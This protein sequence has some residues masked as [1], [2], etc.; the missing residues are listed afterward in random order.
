[1]CF[2]TVSL[3]TFCA[4]ALGAGIAPAQDSKPET[5]PAS[6][7]DLP[8]SASRLDEAVRL[9]AAERYDEAVKVL[10]ALCQRFPADVRAAGLLGSAQLELH[11]YEDAKA[12]Y[13]GLVKRAPKESAAWVGY[14]EALQRLGALDEAA[15]AV[16]RALDLEPNRVE[17]LFS[18]GQ[19]AWRR[20][21]AVKAK[22]WLGKGL[23][24][25]PWGTLAPAA[26]YTLSQ[27]AVLEGRPQD[28]EREKAAYEKK[29]H[30]AE[31]RA[32]MERRL[33]V[34]PDDAAARRVLAGL[35]RE[36]G[37]GL[38][39][40]QVLEPLRREQPKDPRICLEVAE[41]LEVAGRRSDAAATAAEAARLA[42]RS[43]TPLRVLAE[44]RLRAGELDEAWT[45]LRRAL[46]LDPSATAEPAL[47]AAAADLEGAASRAGRAQLAAEVREARRRLGD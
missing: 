7:P 31:K 5:S 32:A 1:V 39:A 12:T 16:G 34:K 19:L 8:E 17:A 9:Y 44:M 10:E 41:S 37:D 40:L 30:W 18:A 3:W 22:E 21:D 29:Y 26:H 20:R 24:L 42:P 43:A 33:T 15:A 28:A 27:V 14:G 2:W 45:A 47:R 4:I 11:R 6:R 23:T 38:R 46:D 35:Y 25:E 36:A 13:A